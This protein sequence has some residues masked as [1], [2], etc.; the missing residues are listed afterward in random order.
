M[1]S[2][3]PGVCVTVGPGVGVGADDTGQHRPA[4][5]GAAGAGQAPQTAPPGRPVSL[6]TLQRGR[7]RRHVDGR[8]GNVMIYTKL[9]NVYCETSYPNLYINYSPPPMSR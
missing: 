4:L 6:Q 7:Q 8:E 9:F 5:P 1:P 3:D 2:Y